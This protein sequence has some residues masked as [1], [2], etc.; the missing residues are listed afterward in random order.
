M[1]MAKS[2]IIINGADNIA[3]A[4]VDLKKGEEHEGVVLLEDITKGHKFALRDIPAGD[5]V[6]KYG[7]S[8]ASAVRDIKQGEHVHIHNVRTNLSENLEYVLC[9]ENK[10]RITE[11]KFVV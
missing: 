1:S 5:Q 8:I 9:F 10:A 2:S 6:I 11:N 4:L 7:S 3:V